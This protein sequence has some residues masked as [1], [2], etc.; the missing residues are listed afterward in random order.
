M[1]LPSPPLSGL[2]RR[3][4]LTGLGVAALAAGL[5]PVWSAA[6]PDRLPPLR[7]LYYTDVHCRPDLGAPEALAKAAEVMRPIPAD[8]VLCGG[9]VINTGLRAPAGDCE[10]LFDIYDGFLKALARPVE[11]ALG[12]HDLAGISD[13]PNPAANPREL[14][15]R[16]LGIVEPYRTVDVGGYRV[17]ILDSVEVIPGPQIYRGYISPVQKA[18]IADEL[19]RIPKEQPIILLTHIPFRST[20]LQAKENPTAAL[21]NNLVVE[22]ANEVLDLF[23]DHRLPVVLQGHL[24]SDEHI[25]WAGQHFIQGGAVCAGWWK[26]PNLQTDFGF[27][28]LEIAD[29]VIRWSYTPYG[30]TAKV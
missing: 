15:M 16:R 6:V 17:M 19:S 26:G 30:W 7:I 8:I 3:Q 23:R 24:H 27:G 5:R 29:N 22:N 25:D 14:A 2:P 1:N 12:N 9:D 10:P 18:W 28:L 21:K 4:F 13:P 20:F 11:H